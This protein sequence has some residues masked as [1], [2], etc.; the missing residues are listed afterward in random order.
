MSSFSREREREIGLTA[1]SPS[2]LPFGA[3]AG[4]AGRAYSA[5]R[6]RRSGQTPPSS[7]RSQCLPVDTCPAVCGVVWRSFARE[8]G[9]SERVDARVWGFVCV[10]ECVCVC[11]SARDSGRSARPSG[12]MLVV[13]TGPHVRI[14]VRV[15][16]VWSC[17]GGCGLGRC[18]KA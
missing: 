7:C 1:G 2:G 9:G 5:R 8:C 15:V 4:V 14:A 10:C 3:G 11:V 13:S 6:P 12:F 16:I 18:A 17:V